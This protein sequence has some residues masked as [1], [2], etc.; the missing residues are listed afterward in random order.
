W[1][2]WQQA[3]VWHAW[4]ARV[5]PL[6][7]SI[8]A[9][10]AWGG[11]EAFWGDANFVE[12]GS[13]SVGAAIG[14]LALAAVMRRRSRL[15]Q[16]SL[17]LGFAAAAL[18]LIAKPPQLY[19][20]V[21]QLP[22]LGPSSVHENHRLMLLVALAASY[23]AACEVERWRRGERAARALA[24]AALVTA[25]LVCW[26]YF[27]H[28]PPGSVELAPQGW[29]LTL[30]L[31]AVALVVSTLLLDSRLRRAADWLLALVVAVELFALHGD[32]TRPAPA[33]LFYPRTP[34]LDFLAEHLAGARLVG[35]VDV[36]PANFAQVYGFSD[37]RI[38]GPAR[39]ATYVGLIQALRDPGPLTLANASQLGQPG[40]R[41]YDLLGVRY[42]L[43]PPGYELPLPVAWR[44]PSLWIYEHPRPL[45]RFF[46]P[47]SAVVQNGGDWGR[48]VRRQRDFAARALVATG[49]GGSPAA[50]WRAR[51]G[52]AAFAATQH[53]ATR[54]SAE[55]QASEP[56]LL[57]GAVY[58]D[59]GWR[60][61]VDGRPH[62][63]V[64]VNGPLL[65]AWLPAGEHRLDLLYRPRR[66]VAGCLLAAL[67][68]AAGL[69]WLMPSPRVRAGV[70]ANGPLES[71][72]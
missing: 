22:L 12:Q 15:P 4:G 71:L 45:P 21:G 65:G 58:Q 37:V 8:F 18:L 49:P 2:S 39:P 47:P 53:E 26:A 63:T 64:A 5:E 48:W 70:P 54:W 25:G 30:Q 69:A 55:L 50:R 16:E 1:S 33:R 7:L 32:A 56:R 61:L 11:H 20:F 28:L 72:R 38:D 60:L 46:L 6:L 31:V 23:L 43:A 10:R 62:E 36:F 40:A 41:L 35:I 67:G 34:G 24:I 27:G 9:V 14:V 66:F 57:T 29:W 3:E 44:D 17:L 59:G 52:R 13:G 51:R 19:R 42:L 68:L